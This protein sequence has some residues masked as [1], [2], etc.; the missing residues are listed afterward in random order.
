MCKITLHHVYMKIS[1]VINSVDKGY[2]TEKI[3]YMTK[4]ISLEVFISE[5]LKPSFQH[6]E[7][8]LH[9]KKLQNYLLDS[10]DK[11]HNQQDYTLAPGW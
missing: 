11:W 1:R 9:V 8:H 6:I 4:K 7:T 3:S 5:S 2:I 10:Q